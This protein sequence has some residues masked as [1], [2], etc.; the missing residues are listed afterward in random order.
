MPHLAGCLFSSEEHSWKCAPGC[1]VVFVDEKGDTDKVWEWH[2]RQ[3]V[4][5]LLLE[6]L[7]A[8]RAKYAPIYGEAL[9]THNGRNVLV[10]A[11]QESMDLC[12]YLRQEVQERIDVGGLLTSEI[13]TSE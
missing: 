9:T 1:G 5:D 3:D 6:D 13:L 12:L 11:Y 8:R 4:T 10:D 2:E 7:K